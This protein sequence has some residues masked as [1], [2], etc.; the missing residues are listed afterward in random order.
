MRVVFYHS[1]NTWIEEWMTRSARLGRLFVIATILFVV[2]HIVKFG[3]IV[4][5]R[6]SIVK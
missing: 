2:Q 4:I 1:L 6:Y 5:V 3:I